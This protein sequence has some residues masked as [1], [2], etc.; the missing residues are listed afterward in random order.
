[1]RLLLRHFML[2]V[3]LF[4]VGGC[5]SAKKSVDSWMG[6]DE[7]TSGSVTTRKSAEAG[8]GWQNKYAASLRVNEY[9]DQRK[10][11]NPRWLGKSRMPIRGMPR[12]QVVIDQEIASAVTSAIK[13]QFSSAGYQVL[14]GGGANN[15]LF[16]V[17]GVIKE[18]SLDIKDRDEINI[19]IETTIKDSATG[20]V[21]WSGL[22]TEKN[23]RFAGVSG[24]TKSDVV[25]YLN[26]ELTIAGN[27][28]V[29][30]V[31]ASL[32][33]SQPELFNQG[34]A[35]KTLPGVTV[36]TTPAGAVAVPPAS[37]VPVVRAAPAAMKPVPG[38]QPAVAP[39]SA[40]VPFTST[41]AGL[42]LVNTTPARAKVYV[43]EVY[44]GLTPLRVEMD[45]GVH[46]ISVK[47][48]GYKMVTEQVSVRKGG[49][50]EMEMVLER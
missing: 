44:F 14:E 2:V 31:T 34:P 29:E 50:T 16:E 10:A 22:V 27:K 24:N 37:V 35:A 5:S 12:N 8:K 23:D 11:A 40:P 6:D 39:P 21:V 46:S 43:D 7:N 9:V 17:S 41:T 48:A 42:L 32:M 38:V 20:Q 3:L 19:S 25:D 1:M 15:A 47:L 28:T 36:Y 26:E 30:A 33:A 49:T 4:A 13:E 18:L 45:P